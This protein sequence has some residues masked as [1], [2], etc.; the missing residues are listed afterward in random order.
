MDGRNHGDSRILVIPNTA[1]PHRLS[2]MAGPPRLIS[3]N[4]SQHLERVREPNPAEL[5]RNHP[6]PTC[7]AT[8]RL[9]VDVKVILTRPVYFVRRTT[10]EIYRVVSE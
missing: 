1:R 6:R 5:L 4:I 3:H 10:N 2:P 7:R 8:T 9:G